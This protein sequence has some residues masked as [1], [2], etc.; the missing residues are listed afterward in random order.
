MAHHAAPSP[1]QQNLRILPWWWVLRWV[2]LG[3][4]IWVLYLTQ[5][6]GISL[7]GVLLF[8][9]VFS[10]V[11]ICSEVPTGMIA[12]RYG[13]RASLMV[14][15]VCVVAAFFT[16]AVSPLLAF[17]LASY[18]LFGMAE[19]L[20]S[21]A[22]SALLFDSLKAEGREHEF[23]AWNG[24]L[25]ALIMGATAIFTIVGSIMVRWTP[26]SVPILLS[27][28]LSIPAIVLAWRMHE[29]P[30]DDERHSYLQTGRL[31]LLLVARSA[32]MRA[33]IVL[34]AVT[35]LAISIMAIT[36]QLVIVRHGMPVW[37]VGLFVA[38]Q[39]AVGAVGSA[40]ADRLGR[41][42]TLRRTFL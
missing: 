33:L 34:M 25:N 27:A 26:L 39:M 37:T 14:G 5:E 42:L 21:G 41:R 13:R 7:G 38:V 23:T 12:D 40:F 19:T 24:R 18:A 8:E 28:A 1:M 4:G 3:E 15:S 11:V 32:P 31:G 20:F 2:W 22:D 30:R 6:R 36:Q 35:T 29:P 9:A 10:A 17:L 16:F